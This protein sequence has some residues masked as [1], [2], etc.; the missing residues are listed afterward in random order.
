[1]QRDRLW[2]TETVTRQSRIVGRTGQ[3]LGRCNQNNVAS[4]HF[5]IIYIP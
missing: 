3:Q 4:W 2:Q 5:S 1:M